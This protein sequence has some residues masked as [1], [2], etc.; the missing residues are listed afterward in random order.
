ML[1]TLGG[2]RLEGSSFSRE[3]PLLLLAYLALEGPRPRRFLAELFWPEAADPM[4]SLAVA[5]A[6]LRKLGV[7]YNDES[8]AWVD[9]DCDALALQDA[10][11]AGRW[12]EGVRLYGGPFAEGLAATEVGSELEEWVYEV[13]ERLGR[14]VRQAHLVLAE[15]AANSA[16]F[17]EA[18]SYAEQAYRVAGAPPLEPEELPRVYRLLLAGEHPLAEA[19]GREARELGITL[20]GSSQAARGRLRQGLV[21]REQEIAALL[22]TQEGAW[23]WVRGGA[24]MGKTALLHE[25]AGRT[26][27][28]YL[29]ARSG[30][31]YATLEPLLENLQG[32]EEALLR[33]AVQL[34]EHLL[35]DDWE[36]M[37]PDSQRILLRLRSLRP[38]IRVVAS[39]RGEPPFAVDGLVE[40]EPLSREALAGYPGAFEA[41]GGVPALVGAWLRGEPIQTALEA[42]LLGLSEPARQ[43]YMGLALLEIPDLL[44]VRQA[45]GLNATEMAQAVDLLL[46]AGLI[47][48]NGAVFGREAALSYIAERPTLEARLS[49]GLARL[50]K[51]QQALPL[52]RRARAL[53]EDSDLPHL[54]QAYLTWATELIRRG[55]PKRAAE[56][57][58]EAPNHPEITLLQA[59]AFERAGLYKEALET[60]R[61]LPETPEHLALKAT[62]FHRLGR[63]EAAQEAAEKALSGGMEARAEA[64]NTL[65]LIFLA[66]GR[67]AEAAGAFRRAAALWLGL[68]DENRRLDALN[69]AAIARARTGEDVAKVFQE[70][71]QAAQ[72][73]PSL[74]AQ[75]LINL[76]KELE[77]Q[78]QFEVALQSYQEAEQLALA[79]GNLKKAALAQNNAGALLH[80]QHRTSEARAYYHRAIEA[81]R[82][83]GEAYVLALALSNLAEL[84]GDLEV[85]QEAIA[86]S[87]NAGYFDLA[88][89][90]RAQMQAFMERSG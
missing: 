36:Q 21:G 73:N 81:A 19:L 55:F 64:Q 48:L 50:L 1:H 29:P 72:D 31:P 63:A 62:L 75:A 39:G 77:R 27:W 8:R 65:G 52:Y 12:E 11:R 10:L 56:A 69:N 90:Q 68:G 28:L 41:T 49:L 60:M 82:E 35:L 76:G 16:K 42:R 80:L 86:V 57:L 71:L 89:Q 18:A 4:N 20:G 23:V 44:L 46:S 58:A 24:G 38:P 83:A 54:R 17:V 78:Q 70:L 14:E 2:L 59:R 84:L 26:G 32:G 6:K 9:L 7:A 66:K 67:F 34:R 88:Q 30:L 5:L 25:V 79:I 51:P 22:A 37:D 61:L 33:R 43:V 3:K 40:L 47:D 87:E 45:V 53:L 74:R 15:K 85:W 13:R